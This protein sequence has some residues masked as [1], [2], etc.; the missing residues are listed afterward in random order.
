MQPAGARALRADDN[1]AY[2]ERE[3]LLSAWEQ[4]S[5]IDEFPLRTRR[6]QRSA[7]RTASTAAPAPVADAP[8]ARERR[9][10]TIT[11]QPTPPRPRRRSAAQQQLVAQPDRVALWA[12]LLG[13]FLVLVAAA[14][15]NAAPL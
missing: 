3:A 15:A 6:F 1:E 12:F 13:L 2:A 14:T 10:V 11:G 4:K 7:E 5:L 9:T 8:P